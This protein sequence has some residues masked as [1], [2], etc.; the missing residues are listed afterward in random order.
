MYE[1]IL[2]PLD[3]SK[4]AEAILPNVKDI[5]SKMSPETQVEVTLLEVISGMTFN[6]LTR[7]RRAQVP[8]K[9]NELEKVKKEALDY[10]EKA[11]ANL[12]SDGVK[13]NIMVSVGPIAEEIVNVAREV[14]ANIIAMS[15]HGFSGLRKWAL[16]SITEEVLKTS[17]IPI[18]VIRA[19]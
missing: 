7:D 16:G 14:K 5:V 17:D 11:A 3:G 10:L 9:K 1:R 8:L 2:V 19:K 18:L 4:V 12:R 6:V 15:T 13:V